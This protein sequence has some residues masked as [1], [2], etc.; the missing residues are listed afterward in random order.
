MIIDVVVGFLILDAIL[1][2]LL[3]YL[4]GG[5]LKASELHVEK[6]LKARDG[7]ID[8]WLRARDRSKN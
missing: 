7:A 4:V 2:L 6:A 3:W 1:A 8:D 5:D